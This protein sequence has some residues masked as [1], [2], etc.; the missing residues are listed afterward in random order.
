[1]KIF[2]NLHITQI[3]KDIL[4]IREYLLN[5]FLKNVLKKNW[6]KKD[7]KSYRANDFEKSQK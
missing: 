1:M 5:T 6:K 3:Q 2:L 7:L 4:H